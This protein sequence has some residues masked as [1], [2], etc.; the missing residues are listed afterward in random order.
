VTKKKLNFLEI[1][2]AKEGA[3]YSTQIGWGTDVD[4]QY[5]PDFAQ[6]EIMLFHRPT[7]TLFVADMLWSLPANEAYLNV[8][9][10]TRVPTNHGQFSLQYAVDH[11]LHPDGWLGKALQWAA[12][13]QTDA[14]KA[15]LRKV[16]EEWQ[17]TTIVMEH[18]DVITSGAHEKLQSTYS[19]IKQ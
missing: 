7:K 16:M 15:G 17:P 12:N 14:L 11:H 8:H 6:K 13:K 10:K 19:W 18:G 9:D 5:F 3:G 1:K 2:D 4:L